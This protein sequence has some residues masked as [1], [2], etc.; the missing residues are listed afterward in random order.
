MRPYEPR[1]SVLRGIGGLS[2]NAGHFIPYSRLTT[3]ICAHVTSIPCQPHS[4]SC[5]NGFHMAP[6][7]LR[8]TPGHTPAPHPRTATAQGC[9]W[10][11]FQRWGCG[12]D[13]VES[14]I[15]KEGA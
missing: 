7:H 6:C 4:S 2:S 3:T 13:Q 14:L 11:A 1:F 15:P 8:R 9:F 5:L 10:R 12:D